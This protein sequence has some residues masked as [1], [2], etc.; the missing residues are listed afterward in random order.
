MDH[1]VEIGALMIVYQIHAHE[2]HV[3]VMVQGPCMLGGLHG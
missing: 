1:T 2:V 3:H